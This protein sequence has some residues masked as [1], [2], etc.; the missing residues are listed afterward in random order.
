MYANICF[1]LSALTLA[2]PVFSSPTKAAPEDS[3]WRLIRV[4]AKEPAKWMNQ[5]EIDKLHLN[6]V[7][8]MDLTWTREMSNLAEATKTRHQTLAIPDSPTQQSVVNPIIATANTDLMRKVLPPLT[9]YNN[10]YY[11]QDTGRQSSEWLLGQVQNLIKSS[12]KHGLNVTVVPF[13]HKWVQNSIIARIEGLKGNQ[14]TVIVGGHQDSINIASPR[15]GRAPGADD[16]GSGVVTIMEAMRVLLESGFQPLRP[17][18]FHWYAGE[19]AGLLGSQA[20]AQQYQQSKRL[21]AGMMQLDMTSFPNPDT[22]DVGIVTDNVDDNLTSLLR[23]LVTTYTSLTSG[24]FECGYAC[25]D[26]AS[27]NEAGYPSSIPFESSNMEENQNLHTP[28]DTLETVNYD[29]ALNFVKLAV[30]FV[31][32]LAHK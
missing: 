10:R 32:E 21:V 19:E 14:E 25:S 11:T 31:V 29:H 30:A 15:T 23:S 22:P 3:D 4:S 2:L 12:N 8:F 26:H 13:K 27:W 9:Q 6:K 16:D 24:D 18:E 1:L 28:K 17:V 20:I 5:N 7:R